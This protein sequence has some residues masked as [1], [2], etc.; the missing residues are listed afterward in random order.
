MRNLRHF[1]LSLLL[2]TLIAA[3]AEPIA[4]LAGSPSFPPNANLLAQNIPQ[5]P[6]SLVD[7]AGPYSGFLGHGFV[8]WH[9]TRR[10]MLIAHRKAGSSTSQVFLLKAPMD[11]PQQITDSPDPVTRA[12]YE[13]RNG[14]YIVFE[15]SSGGN[16]A[17][18]LYRLPLG[19]ANAKPELLSN[20]DERNAIIAWL[21]HGSQMIY[22]SLPLDRT[23]QGG[24]RAKVATTLW[25]MDPEKPSGRRKL[26]ELDGGGWFWGQPSRDDKQLAL[27]RYISAN[28]SQVWLLD[29]DKGS[30]QQ[31][32]PATSRNKTAASHFAGPFSK[33]RRHLWISTDRFGEFNELARLDLSSGEIARASAHIH[34]DV[35]EITLSEDGKTMAAL[36]NVDGRNELRLFNADTLAEL[37][38]PKLPPGNINSPAYDRIRNELSFNTDSAQGPGQIFTLRADGIAEQW[39][40]AHAPAGVDPAKFTE[41]QIVKWTSFD[42]T[43]ISGLLTHPPR[44]FTGKR[45]VL[46][47]IHGGPEGQSIFGFLGRS[48]YFPQELGMAIIQPNVRG[49]TGFGKSFQAMDNGFKRENSVKDIGALLDW[50]A[51]QP[52]LDASRVMVTGGSYGGYMALSAATHFSDQIAGAIDVVGISHFVTFL[53]NTESYRR[54]LRRAE[55]GDERDPAMAEHLHAISPLTNAAK[56]KSP[57]FVIQ[58]KNDPRVPF[59]E[60]E[61]IVDKVRQSGSP[62]WYLRAENEGHGFARKENQDYQFYATILFIKQTL[63]K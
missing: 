34:W 29:I 5:I 54:D 37:P 20:P 40:R 49:S 2:P 51:T 22:S 43:T 15:R 18:Q 60:A 26:I 27:T 53:Q 58:G 16:E 41:Q 13:P 24:S 36:F 17:A 9:P 14:R 42:G 47:S 59:T 62:V 3:Q 46:I 44:S 23:A 45:P 30:I 33:D 19:Q 7:S 39:T 21:R 56:I 61:Q 11:S 52:D 28:E 38:A 55:Y 31:A 10:Q 32:L 63:F 12:T 35:S 48:A 8:E 6:Q 57:L 50:I 25:L 1:A 4:P